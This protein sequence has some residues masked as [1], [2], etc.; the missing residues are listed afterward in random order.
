MSREMCR[1][2]RVNNLVLLIAVA[3]A[4]TACSRPASVR[5]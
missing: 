3:R 4:A 5:P 2:A 1:S